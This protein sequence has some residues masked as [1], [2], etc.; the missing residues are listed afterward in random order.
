MAIIFSLKKVVLV[1]DVPT[2]ATI[3]VLD[4]V[5]LSNA[6]VCFGYVDGI[7]AT[8]SVSGLQLADLAGAESF[9]TGLG[10]LVTF[11]KSSRNYFTE[12]NVS[13]AV[14]KIYLFN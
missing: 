14:T 13:G 1:D 11:D 12:S 6:E 5:T 8:I 3:K 10:D 9:L 7:K 4:D 2:E